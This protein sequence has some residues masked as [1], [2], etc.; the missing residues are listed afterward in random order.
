[1]VT[2]IYTYFRQNCRSTNTDEMQENVK[3]TNLEVQPE[4][5]EFQPETTSKIIYPPPTRAHS[6]E[7]LSKQV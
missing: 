2:Q 6:L 4:N 7:I 5:L 3:A 1:M